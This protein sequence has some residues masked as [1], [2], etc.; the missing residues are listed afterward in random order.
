VYP[1]YH[2]E[3]RGRGATGT[4]GHR[5][6]DASPRIDP[7][8]AAGAADEPRLPVWDSHFGAVA[9]G[10]LGCVRLDLMAAIEAPHEKPDARRGG[11]AEGY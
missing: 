10:H 11:V 4:L 8:A 6:I 1:I 7:P 2:I 3:L 9:L 5:H